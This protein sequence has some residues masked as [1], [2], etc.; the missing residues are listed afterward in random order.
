[1]CLERCVWKMCL[2]SEKALN[3]ASLDP[4]F[5]FELALK[6]LGPNKLLC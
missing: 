4:D 1:M 5:V 6:A 3:F 2:G